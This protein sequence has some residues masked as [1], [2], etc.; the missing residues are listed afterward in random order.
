MSEDLSK[1]LEEDD[2]VDFM[3]LTLSREIQ[4]ALSD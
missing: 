3:E 4:N 2:Y 1:F